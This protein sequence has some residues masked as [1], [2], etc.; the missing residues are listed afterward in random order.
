MDVFEGAENNFTQDSSNLGPSQYLGGDSELNSQSN[1]T[2]GR[3]SYPQRDYDDQERQYGSNI[4]PAG[5]PVRDGRNN[6]PRQRDS[7][8]EFRVNLANRNQISNTAASNTLYSK[9]R[10]L[11]TGELIIKQQ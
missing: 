9:Q 3:P 6:D 2:R 8:N 5:D 11:A 1:Y 4:G 7:L 10:R